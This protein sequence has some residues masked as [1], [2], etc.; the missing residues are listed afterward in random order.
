MSADK[1]AGV[2]LVAALHGAA[3]WGLWSH[4]LLSPM[5]DQVD[6]VPLFVSVVAPPSPP[7][8]PETRPLAKTPPP[9][10]RPEP[11]PPPLAAPVAAV[12][13]ETAVA[14]AP[15][16]APMVAAPVEAR[17]AMPVGPVSLGAEL[18][19]S[20]SE[21]PAPN[22]PLAAR[23]M[24]E[25]GTTM[26]RVELDEQGRISAASVATSSGFARLDEAALAAVRNWRC[27]PAQRNGQAVRAVAMQAFKFV[28]QGN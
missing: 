1:V 21:R 20:C 15:T 28:L 24:N 7:P 8:V 11:S 3:L 10:R 22:Y 13:A 25:S 23:R 2:L 26:L 18:A 12:P 14:P 4:R 19:V 27:N 16:P 9:M 5:Q 6:Q 17:P